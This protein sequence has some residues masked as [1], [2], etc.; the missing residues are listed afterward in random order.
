ML[1]WLASCLGLAVNQVSLD[2][3][4]FIWGAPRSGTTLLYE[5]I[6]KHPDVGYPVS[7]K[8]EPREGTGFWWGAFGEHRGAMDKSLVRRKGIQ[9]IT[10][11]YIGLLKG[12]G[13][14]RL[15]DKIPFMTLWIPLVNEVFPDARHFHII[16]DG[17]AVVNSILYKLRYSTREKDQLYRK[18]KLMYGP[19]PPELTDPMSL[20]PAKRH[21][22]QWIML[23]QHGRQNA[24]TLGER[25][26][27]V[28][29]EDLV[30]APR[31]TMK[32][33]FHHARL[34][35]DE[36]LVAEAYL[37]KLEN[38]NY[39]WMTN[40]HKVWSN[41]FTAR[42]TLRAADF[43]HLKEMGPLLHSLGYYVTEDGTVPNTGYR[44]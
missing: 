3:P 24:V 11:E 23:V 18:E 42:R 43:F 33:I 5:L 7:N 13:K 39:K 22:R 16:R 15:L 34:E 41:G 26:C 21:A 25:Y 19:Q 9:Q 44:K 1:K 8:K 4:I 38:R 30:S 20:P 14:F 17:R 40:Q 28:R 31:P 37:E 32:A 35:Y 2:R 10:S 27:E 29:Y 12:Q 6:A 36:Q